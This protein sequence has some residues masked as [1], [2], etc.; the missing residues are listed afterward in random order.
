M[1]NK[2]FKLHENETILEDDYPVHPLY[3]Y[4]ADGKLIRSV[5]EGTVD[6]LKEYLGAKEIRRYEH[7]AHE[8]IKMGDM[9]E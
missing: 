7:F 2:V 4:I 5:V 6:D 3:T 1:K 9:L 8:G